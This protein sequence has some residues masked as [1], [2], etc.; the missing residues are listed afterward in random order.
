MRLL[1][2]VAAGRR[3]NSLQDTGWTF[4]AAIPTDAPVLI[5][6]YPPSENC[7]A[8]AERARCVVAACP[9]SPEV[10]RLREWEKVHHVEPDIAR[11]I[12]ICVMNPAG[13][14]PFGSEV[15]SQIVLRGFEQGSQPQGFKRLTGKAWEKLIVGLSACLKPGGEMCVF[16]ENTSLK[17]V[18]R[19]RRLSG[20][21]WRTASM[22]R[23]H[24]FSVETILY[25]YP[26][27]GN[28]TEVSDKKHK[29][30][31]ASSLRERIA[32]FL[33]SEGAMI[34]CKKPGDRRYKSVTEQIVEKIERE[35]GRR[36]TGVIRLKKGSGG[37]Y[38]LQAGSSIARLPRLWRSE[39]TA[40]WSNNF[41]ALVGLKHASLPF[42]VPEAFVK[43]IASGQ[44]YS[45]ESKL[46]GRVD[47]GSAKGDFRA[48]RLMAQAVDNLIALFRNTCSFGVLGTSD[49][50]RLFSEPIASA[51]RHFDAAG[52]DALWKLNDRL[53]E[54]FVGTEVPLATTHGDFKRSNFLLD[55]RGRIDGIFDWDLSRS[56]GLPMLDL[57]LFLGFEMNRP[58]IPTQIMTEFIDKPPLNN[59]FVLRYVRN[60]YAVSESRLK[61]LALLTV[62][63]Y[64]AYHRTVLDGGANTRRTLEAVLIRARGLASPENL[65][66]QTADLRHH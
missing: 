23:R 26:A 2:A 52:S 42:K 10:V 43:G 8:L 50:L 28:V 40:R 53:R 54:E 31:A 59:R 16:V 66:P 25:F 14:M 51:A 11:K 4:F 33:K 58:D 13:S 41:E 6:E 38:V 34:V 62:I 1:R 7:Y 12:Q 55:E 29:D 45:V 63:Y 15:F 37:A 48:Q 27:L 49:F 60:T 19:K 36:D 17:T 24:S 47:E 30:G 64:L 20:S 22:L 61:S 35:D 56:P 44:P 57:Y 9:A 39:N 18:L 46:A 21:V 3:K 32:P 5:V 65:T